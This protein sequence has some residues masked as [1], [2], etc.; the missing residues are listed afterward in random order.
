MVGNEE[1]CFFLHFSCTPKLFDAPSGCVMADPLSIIASIAGVATAGV[2]LANAVYRL[3]DKLVHAPQSMRDIASNMSLLSTILEN[4]AEVLQQGR[5][6]YKARVLHET[7]A[8]LDRFKGVQK[9]VGKIVRKQRGFRRRLGWALQ[10]GKA[11]ELLEK[12]EALKS[13]LNLVLWTVHL[14]M[15][16][17]T[18]RP[19]H[20]K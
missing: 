18:T 12:I 4:L 10:Y 3:S 16:Q 8:L 5:G 14:A 6:V 17:K 19:S 7:E 9:E 15:S 11:E 13:A 20:E 2:H 1:P